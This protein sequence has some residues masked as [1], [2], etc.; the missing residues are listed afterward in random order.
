[1]S[2]N[3][4]IN[5]AVSGLAASQSAIATTSQNVA[6]ANTVGYTRQAVRF[7]Q[8]V[9]GTVANGVEI[10]GIDRF[11][12]VFL[13]RE[14]RAATSEGGDA[15]A[16]E[17]LFRQVAAL[18]GAPGSDASLA[19]DLSR[20]ATA[21]DRLSV[22]P[23]DAALR[24]DA[25]AT[26][27]TVARNT[28]QL[29]AD[30]QALRGES[31]RQIAEVVDQIN[32]QLQTIFTLNRE[33]SQATTSGNQAPDLEDKRDLAIMALSRLTGISTF[34]RDNGEVVVF[35]S[36]GHALVDAQLRQLQYATSSTVVADT[37]FRE[38]TAVPVDSQ[39]LAPTGAGEILVTAGTSATVVSD[40]EGGRLAGL[41]AMR[42]AELPTIADQIEAFAVAL[43]DAV[44]AVHND[45]T[46]FPAPNALT[47][48]RAVAGADAFAATGTAR[49][50]ILD[51]AGAIVGTP[52]DLD[53]GALGATTVDNL[54]L[55]I[56]TAL[57]ADGT[58]ALVNGR[59]VITATNPAHGVAINEG[60]SAVTATGRG[61]AHHFGLNDFF[62]GA[63]AA[64][65][66]VRADIRSDPSRVATAELSPT[67]TAGQAGATIGDNRIAS[68]LAEV[69]ET[70]LAFQ[71]VGG[72]PAATVTLGSFASTVIGLTAT[73][74]ATAADDVAQRAALV[75][76][77]EFR[78]GAQSGVS[79]DEELSNLILFQNAYQA[80]ARVMTV[81]KELFDTL[82]DMV[83]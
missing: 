63:G 51:G 57:G 15:A 21:L 12:D 25:V 46:S 52:L 8:R 13:T 79:V 30:V 55:T 61:L 7:E 16:R 31:D 60:T 43:R 9:V 20:F 77:L 2:L 33:I 82:I 59:L 68:R 71:A 14:L 70:T 32:Q 62:V 4:I 64:D 48:T 10:A 74:A 80:S 81:A 65:L 67:A 36:T 37:A 45:G 73:R 6:N 38:I 66:A 56:N 26:G 47:G 3:L 58:A 83:R 34:T 35:T 44:N 19:N 75:A 11:V 49:I 53:L 39:T 28:R 29:A 50:A 27:E 69:F 22:N 5:S 54:V 72:L 1:M 18:F 40:V 24:F 42:D 17:E 76:S 23:E 78:Q 41:L